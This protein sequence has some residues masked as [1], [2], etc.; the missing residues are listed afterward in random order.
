MRIPVRILIVDDHQSVRYALRGLLTQE[1]HWQVFEAEN[2]K[3]AIQRVREIKPHVVVLDVVMPGMSGIETAFEM[4]RRGPTPKIILISS[5]YTPEEAEMIRR[6]YADGD[7]IQK[8]NAGKE[9][10]PAISRLLPEENQGG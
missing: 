10:I 1:P 6:L 5:H 7:F 4:R 8:S 2:G 3:I 9:L